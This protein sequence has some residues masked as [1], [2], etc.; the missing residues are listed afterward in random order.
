MSPPVW[1]G[2]QRLLTTPAL[3]GIAFYYCL[4][5]ALMNIKSPLDKK[6]PFDV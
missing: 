6:A 4:C 2:A 1:L 3:P 5:V